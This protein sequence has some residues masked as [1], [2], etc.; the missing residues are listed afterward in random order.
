MEHHPQT[1]QKIGQPRQL[2]NV[3]SR[4]RVFHTDL[5][6]TTT[7][8]IERTLNEYACSV[9]IQRFVVATHGIMAKHK[10]IITWVTVSYPWHNGK[11]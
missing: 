3:L 5:A 9:I 7:F 8:L 6:T 2:P 1:A 11:A 10:S 4:L